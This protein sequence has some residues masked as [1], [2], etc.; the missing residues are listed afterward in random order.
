M[1][2]PGW[3]ALKAEQEEEAPSI[4]VE[5]SDA[6]GAIVSR[7]DATNSAG[8]LYSTTTSPMSLPSTITSAMVSGACTMPTPLDA[9]ACESMSTSS[10]RLSRSAS[11]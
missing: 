6:G 5:I 9:F 3:D 10:T 2:F 1:P 8:M 11:G 7:F 4:E